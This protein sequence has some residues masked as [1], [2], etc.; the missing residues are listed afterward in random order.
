MTST[1]LTGKIAATFLVAGA[2][3]LAA[4]QASKALVRA[5]VAPGSNH[6]VVPG[7]LSIQHVENPG[8]SFGLGA[9]LGSYLMAPVLLATPFIAAAMI[10]HG[11]PAGLTAVGAGLVLA[12]G[13][14]NMI[15]RARQHGT[16]TDFIGVNHLFTCNVADIGVSAGMGMLL[17][18]NFQH[19]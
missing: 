6:V 8:V 12:G 1:A 13:A 3:T 19:V 14:G 11:A 7:A 16:V 5:Q 2:A 9:G 10:K 15:D 18:A 17:L 4:D